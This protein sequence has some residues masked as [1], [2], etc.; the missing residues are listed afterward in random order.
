MRLGIRVRLPDEGRLQRSRSRSD[1]H[2]HFP[3]GVGV[4][5]PRPPGAVRIAV[6]RGIGRRLSHRERA[7]Q[8]AVQAQLQRV[9]QCERGERVAGIPRQANRDDVVAVLREV[10]P[11]LPAATRAVR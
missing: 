7:N 11:E 2:A 5:L 1:R 6:G 8:F 9:L 10:V 4:T 3:A